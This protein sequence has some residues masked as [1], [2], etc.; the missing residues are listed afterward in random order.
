MCCWG[1]WPLVVGVLIVS[2]RGWLKKVVM[3]L[4]LAIEVLEQF[5]DKED[6]KVDDA[7]DS[8]GMKQHT[9]DEDINEINITF[10]LFE[11]KGWYR[12]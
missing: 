8:E 10:Y 1:Q 12:S 5:D 11:Q 6:N 7:V 3:V 9:N 2:E 4:A